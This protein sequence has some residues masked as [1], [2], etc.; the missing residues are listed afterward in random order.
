MSIKIASNIE[1][2]SD[3]IGRISEV[4]QKIKA[5]ENELNDLRINRL[6]EELKSEIEQ[7]ENLAKEIKVCEKKLRHNAE[8]QEQLNE[9]LN[10]VDTLKAAY[11]TK[12]R[13]KTMEAELKRKELEQLDESLLEVKLSSKAQTNSLLEEIERAKESLRRK[14]FVLL[15]K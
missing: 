5:C 13:G 4:K 10:E 6:K 15:K 1:R 3:I 9:L 8:L 12:I 14:S 2:N 7:Q 11:N